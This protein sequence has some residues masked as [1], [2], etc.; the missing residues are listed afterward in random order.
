MTILKAITIHII[1]G[2]AW[3]SGMTVAYAQAIR[4]GL[5]N[6]FTR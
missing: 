3:L 4:K 6:A 1:A 5:R 2:A